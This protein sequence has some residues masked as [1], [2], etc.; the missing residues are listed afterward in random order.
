MLLQSLVVIAAMLV[1]TG[2]ILLETLLTARSSLHQAM[3]ARTQTAMT[4][5]TASFVQWAQQQVA[6][7]GAGNAAAWPAQSAPLQDN[8]ICPVASAT[9]GSTPPPCT[10]AAFDT[11]QIR[12]STNG[13]N[14]TTNATPAPGIADAQNLAPTVNEQ[15]LAAT[16]TVRITDPTG[17]RTYADRTRDV[18]ARI[19]EA[20]PY[21]VVTGERDVTAEVGSIHADEGDTGGSVQVGVASGLSYNLPNPTHPSASTDTRIRTSVDCSNRLNFDSAY[22]AQRAAHGEIDY[23]FHPYGNQDWAYEI[24]CDPPNGTPAPTEAAPGY[25]PPIG[26]TF[27]AYPGSQNPVPW[28]PGTGDLQSFAR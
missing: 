18:T 26:T 15:R 22:T 20:P 13:S 21:V 14:A 1:L 25:L 27:S 24:A 23:S 17:R 16:I 28:N 2:S 9:T 12:G 3:A 11:W 19:F 5:A 10:F 6:T 7:Y 8:N 4:D